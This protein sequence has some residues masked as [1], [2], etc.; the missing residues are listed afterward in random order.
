MRARLTSSLE[1]T[2]LFFNLGPIRLIIQ[3]L[4]AALLAQA[5]P[6]ATLTADCGI[7]DRTGKLPILIQF[8]LPGF[9]RIS[10]GLA[11]VCLRVMEFSSSP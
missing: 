4:A 7:G 3:I 10:L 9:L 11:D 1:L 8:R 2:A 6:M 5:T